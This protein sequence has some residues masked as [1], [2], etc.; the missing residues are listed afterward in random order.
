MRH[1]FAAVLAAATV[2][3]TVSPAFA[4]PSV[5]TD[6]ALRIESMCGDTVDTAKALVQR[7]TSAGPVEASVPMTPDRLIQI[8][9]SVETA[10]LFEYPAYFNPPFEGG[11]TVPYPQYKIRVQVKGRVHEV[12]WHAMRVASPEAERLSQFVRAVY[13]VF[14]AVPAVQALPPGAPCI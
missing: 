3:G 14:R 5:P 10:R 9:Q 12:E 4:Q 6:F 8:F 1:C 13:A 11:F 7:M 2:A